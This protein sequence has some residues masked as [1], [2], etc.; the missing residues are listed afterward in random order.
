MSAISSESLSINTPAG[1]VGKQAAY[2]VDQLHDAP[3]A[4]DKRQPN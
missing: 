4:K 2:L 3:R 1:D